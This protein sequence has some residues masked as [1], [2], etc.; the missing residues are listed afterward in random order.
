MRFAQHLSYNLKQ[1]LPQ[2]AAALTQQGE[3]ERTDRLTAS[4]QEIF[5]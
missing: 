2:G 1:E 3:I 4:Q 5:G